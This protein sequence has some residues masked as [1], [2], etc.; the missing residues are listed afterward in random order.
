MKKMVITILILLLLAPNSF[1]A[2]DNDH[3]RKP[4]TIN[5]PLGFSDCDIKV[6]NLTTTPPTIKCVKFD[7]NI[8]LIIKRFLQ[9][10]S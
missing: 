9:E 6:I 5:I 4:E 1:G 2:P 10:K 3:S 8:P 7:F